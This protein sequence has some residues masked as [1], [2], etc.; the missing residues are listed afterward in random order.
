[1][2]EDETCIV[3]AGTCRGSLNSIPAGSG[4]R[5]CFY[6]DRANGMVELNGEMC[7]AATQP[8]TK[9]FTRQYMEISAC[10]LYIG[11]G[12]RQGTHLRKSSAFFYSE[13]IPLARRRL[14][15]CIMSINSASPVLGN[16]HG[17]LV[18]CERSRS[19]IPALPFDT[20]SASASS[21]C[22]ICPM[23]QILSSCKR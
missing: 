11:I 2:Y 6:L 10:S 19:T 16:E 21:A 20:L 13:L 8:A 1:M 5:V 3:K 12:D 23:P 14:L 22:L 9:Q 17:A 18:K 4:V 7:A 15:L